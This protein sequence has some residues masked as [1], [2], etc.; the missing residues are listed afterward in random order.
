VP[1]VKRPMSLEV[2]LM[3]F[4]E[5]L[6]TDLPQ[7]KALSLAFA[8]LYRIFLAAERVWF[9]NRSLAVIRFL[10]NSSRTS[11]VKRDTSCVTKAM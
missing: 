11:E 3:L 4:Y 9:H 6:S 5:L 2:W 1:L 10:G 8:W 7:N